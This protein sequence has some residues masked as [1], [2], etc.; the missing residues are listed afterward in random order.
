MLTYSLGDVMLNKPI[1]PM[2][3]EKSNDPPSSSDWIHQLKFDGFRCLLSYDGD[4]LELFSRHK[5]KCTKQ[6]P[7]IIPSFNADSVYLDGE[8]VVIDENGKPCLELVMTRFNTDSERSIKSLSK[9]L[10]CT[11]VAFDILHLNGNN[12]INLPLRERL[13]IL[14]E[15]V[16]PSDNFIVCPTFDDG[17]SLFESTK[18]LNLEGIV[19]K[20]L[21]SKY[22][23]DKRVSDWLKIKN[24]QYETVQISALR[25]DEFGWILLHDGKYVGVCEFVPPNERKAF[26]QIAKQLKVKEDDKWIY[27]DPMVKCKVKFQAYTKSGMMRTPSFVEFVY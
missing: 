26:Y 19:S 23:L 7:E 2:L 12:L 13:Q 20:N 25:K 1:K 3:L 11:Y 4:K 9:S 16:V 6:F 24:W 14:N 18:Q 27:L 22:V 5:N 21:N 10:P 15:V 17:E 8:M